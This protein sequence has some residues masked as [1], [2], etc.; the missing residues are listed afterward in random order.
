MKYGGGRWGE[1]GRTCGGA[2]MEGWMGVEME[3]TVPAQVDGEDRIRSARAEPVCVPVTIRGELGAKVVTPS[4]RARALGVE[5]LL[6][7]A[8]H[9]SDRVL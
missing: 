6:I 8:T 4:E 3:Q 1:R 9:E 5:C 2:D 7:K